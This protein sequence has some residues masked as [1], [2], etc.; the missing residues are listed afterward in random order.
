MHS[1]NKYQLFN[2]S[3]KLN[4]ILRNASDQKQSIVQ[5]FM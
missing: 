4:S 5:K 1:L 3:V 2:V